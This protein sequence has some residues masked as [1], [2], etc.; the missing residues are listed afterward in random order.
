MDI[1]VFVLDD[2]PL[3]IEGIRGVIE[4]QRDMILLGWATNAA[5]GLREMFRIQPSVCILDLHLPD[6]NG[7]ELVEKIRSHFP[8][9]RVLVFSRYEDRLFAERSLRAG[10]NGYLEK[11]RDAGSLLTAIRQVHNGGVY[12][13]Q[14]TT[15]AV[16]SHLIPS[17]GSGK[18]SV[19]SLSQREFDIFERLGRGLTN[20]EIA[21]QCC[22]SI[23]TVETYYS[24]IKDKL[25]L[26]NTAQMRQFAIEWSKQNCAA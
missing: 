1:R 22:L 19:E 6:A 16:L 4:R 18:P 20:P 13:S 8:G 3:L 7:L 9:T 17:N 2:H 11:T 23:R 21:D 14:D 5:E 26:A 25:Q 24:R 10:A 15:N 12:L